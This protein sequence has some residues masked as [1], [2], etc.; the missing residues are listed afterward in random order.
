MNKELQEGWAVVAHAFNPNTPM[1]QAGESLN[2]RPPQS[3]EQ[4]PGHPGLHRKTLIVS[5]KTKQNK[6]SKNKLHFMVI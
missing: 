3:T 1:A 5:N 6:K 2:L 4:V